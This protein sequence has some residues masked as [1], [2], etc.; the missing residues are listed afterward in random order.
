M[1]WLEF[2]Q[3][4]AQGARAKLIEDRQR[5]AKIEA[6]PASGQRQAEVPASGR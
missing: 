2:A 1:N 6:Q 3:R 5:L 4:L